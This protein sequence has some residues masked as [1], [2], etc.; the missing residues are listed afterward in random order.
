MPTTDTRF[1]ALLEQ[2]TSDL[3]SPN[4]DTRR[5]AVDELY[6]LIIAQYADV[7]TQIRS[8]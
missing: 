8:R 7:S 1:S 2:F 4:E 5:K 6:A 3:Q